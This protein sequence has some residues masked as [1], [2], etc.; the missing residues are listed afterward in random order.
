MKLEHVSKITDIPVK[1]LKNM[2]QSLE[3]VGADNTNRTWKMI[4]AGDDRIKAIRD[5]V[6]KI[7]ENESIFHSD[8]DMYTRGRLDPFFS[9]VKRNDFTTRFRM[10][11]KPKAADNRKILINIMG[12]TNNQ[13]TR[14]FLNRWV[15]HIDAIKP[16]NRIK[17]YGQTS[18]YY[19]FRDMNNFYPNEVKWGDVHNNNLCGLAFDYPDGSKSNHIAWF[20]NKRNKKPNLRNC[21]RDFE[22]IK[23]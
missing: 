5:L 22:R 14:E 1:N 13:Y 23:S 2:K 20:A 3:Q 18:C 6:N 17:G 4:I 21:Y 15:Y 7:P 8:I 19:A 12:F 11:Q 10:Y 16:K 9:I